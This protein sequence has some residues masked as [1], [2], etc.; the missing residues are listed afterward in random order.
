MGCELG[1]EAC[2]GLGLSV[3][4]IWRMGRDELWMLVSVTGAWMGWCM[5]CGEGLVGTDSGVDI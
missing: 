1:G 2:E 4:V 5:D 3:L